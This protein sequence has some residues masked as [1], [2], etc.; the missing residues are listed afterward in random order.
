MACEFSRRGGVVKMQSKAVNASTTGAVKVSADTGYTGLSEV[1]VNQVM[2]QEKTATPSAAQQTFTPDSGYA[3]ISKMTV[4]AAPLQT[5]SV[6]PSSSQQVITPG[7][8]Y[9]GMSKVTVAGVT[10]YKRWSYNTNGS[11]VTATSITIPNT[12]GLTSVFSVQIMGDG[13]PSGYVSS[14]SVATES[15]RAIV[16]KPVVTVGTS[17]VTFG[18]GYLMSDILSFSI[19]ASSIT[20]TLAKATASYQFKA[21]GSY[22]VHVYGT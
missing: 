22:Y 13:T 1:T 17:T 10:T 12:N 6:T 20:I 14:V 18:T 19:T 9:I 2:V 5:R 16:L 3:G 15:E 11:N 4:N 21:G 8:G 7:S